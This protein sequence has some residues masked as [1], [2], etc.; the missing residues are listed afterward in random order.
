[1]V[2]DLTQLL[3]E[4]D[5]WKARNNKLTKAK[6]FDLVDFNEDKLFSIS[7]NLKIYHSDRINPENTK[8]PKVTYLF[9]SKGQRRTITDLNYD[10]RKANWMDPNDYDAG[11]KK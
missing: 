10:W 9:Q 1:M 7:E 6:R 2:K 4:Q 11:G 8:D 5:Q 3:A